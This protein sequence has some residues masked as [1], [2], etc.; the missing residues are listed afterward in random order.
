M[1][2]GVVTS[3]L[4]AKDLFTKDASENVTEI[5]MNGHH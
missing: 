5:C 3:K 4:Q 1:I 2:R